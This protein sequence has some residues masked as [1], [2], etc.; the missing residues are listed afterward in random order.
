MNLS[1]T[2]FLERR[3]RDTFDLRWFTPTVEVELCGHATLAS[4]HVLWKRG[5]SSCS[6]K[7]RFSTRSGVLTAQQRE[8][9]IELDFPSVVDEPVAP[10][11]GL[12]DALGADPKYVGRNKFDYLVEL[13]S[14]A[15]VRGSTPTCIGL[16]GLRRGA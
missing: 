12:V 5:V 14:E 11:A 13:S 6:T 4:A 2:A 8:G 10:P 3:S 9:V 7:L 15:V 1:E 16:G